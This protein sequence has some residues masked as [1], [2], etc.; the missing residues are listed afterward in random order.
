VTR[1][2][3]TN[4]HSFFK[5]RSKRLMDTIAQKGANLPSPAD[6]GK[7]RPWARLREEKDELPSVRSLSAVASIRPTPIRRPARV[8]HHCNYLDA[9]GRLVYRPG[10]H[11]TPDDIGPGSYDDMT[12]PPSRIS[13]I[14]HVGRRTGYGDPS[15]VPSPD[16]YCIAP[17]ETRLPPRIG[18]KLPPERPIEVH[19]TMIGAPGWRVPK[20]PNSAFQTS[21][22]RRP[23]GIDPRENRNPGPGDYSAV[24]SFAR[25]PHFEPGESFGSRE[26]R[27]PRTRQ[28]TTP[29]PS[30]YTIVF[31][32]PEPS[33]AGTSH[34][35]SRTEQRGSVSDTPEGIGPGSYEA[36]PRRNCP[37]NSPAFADRSLRTTAAQYVT[38]SPADYPLPV[39]PLKLAG[40]RATRYPVHGDWVLA[41][42]SDA[43]S[44]ENYTIERGIG[45]RRSTF[46]KAEFVKERRIEKVGPG[47]YETATSNLIKK[48]FNA[49]VPRVASAL[50]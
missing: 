50:G 5:S 17:L 1:A 21:V 48:S 28:N 18:E 3:L 26:V 16:S 47:S 32:R 43:P 24:D 36:P 25:I 9:K 44:P 11:A 13:E 6:Y 10:P 29:S 2:T 42:L 23:F 38:P 45:K 39:A 15:D 7:V 20:R 8:E 14:N 35:L 19:D 37:R 49:N 41:N 27:F 12:R 40:V 34:F 22:P 33:R 4:V 46:P 30:D 31:P